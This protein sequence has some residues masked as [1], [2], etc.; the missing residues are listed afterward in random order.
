VLISS[1]G[2]FQVT[3]PSQGRVIYPFEFIGQSNNATLTRA[4]WASRAHDLLY[5]P[6]KFTQQQ[7]EEFA[8]EII[9]SDLDRNFQRFDKASLS[10]V[11]GTGG[12]RAVQ[13]KRHQ[14]LAIIDNPRNR[15][16]ISATLNQLQMQKRNNIHLQ[17][18]LSQNLQD[19]N[20]YSASRMAHLAR[21]DKAFRQGA[22]SETDRLNQTAELYRS[23]QSVSDLRA[24]IIETDKNIQLE[25]SKLF[26]T[27]TSYL[28]Q[29]LVFAKDDAEI[30]QVMLNQNSEVAPGQVLMTLIWRREI[31]ADKVPVFMN[32]QA[33]AQIRPGMSTISTPLGF[34]PAEIGGIKGIVTELDPLPVSPSE[35]S[36]RVGSAGIGQ[37]VSQSGGLFQANMQ[38]TRIEL[39][40]LRNLQSA[41]RNAYSSDRN[42]G[43]YQWNN[44]SGPPIPPRE[45]FLMATQIT[46]RYRTPLEMLLPSI[47]EVLGMDTPEKLI[48]QGL[49]QP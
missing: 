3:S 45:G 17:A 31:A 26:T 36:L 43:G 5:S 7:V 38:L 11:A 2:F 33:I 22:L 13:V 16:E 44:K 9:N 47:R 4:P 40:N 37:L 42:R 35:I 20:Q 27:L 34:S 41:Y 49:K 15:A 29:S 10:G 28:S 12:S 14:L 39:T 32:Q 23:R 6:E 18:L 25:Y 46:T 24:K 30:S 1:E 8:R 48:R 21:V 19:S